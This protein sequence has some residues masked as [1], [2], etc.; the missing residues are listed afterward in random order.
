MGN[1]PLDSDRMLW[2]WNMISVFYKEPDVK[3]ILTQSDCW[4]NE[5]VA[6][7]IA[8]EAFRIKP[9]VRGYH[10]DNYVP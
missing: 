4:K 2:K 6:H 5:P 1:I 9:R 3:G 10:Y 8:F 7:F